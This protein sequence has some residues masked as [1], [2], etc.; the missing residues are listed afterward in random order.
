MFRGVS[1]MNEKSVTFIYKRCCEVVVTSTRL[2]LSVNLKK[3]VNV[4]CMHIVTKPANKL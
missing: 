1:L 2:W 4:N 3:S